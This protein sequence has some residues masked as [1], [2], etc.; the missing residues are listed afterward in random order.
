M[1][2][3]SVRR[4]GSTAYR[5]AEA[6]NSYAIQLAKAQGHVNG[7]VGG[8]QPMSHATLA[9]PV[10]TSPHCFQPSGIHLSSD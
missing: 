9:A 5:T 8:M 6:A 1:L 2:A 4:F 3:H 7:F 10:L